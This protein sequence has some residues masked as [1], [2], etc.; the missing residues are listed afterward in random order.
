LAWERLRDTPNAHAQV[1][2]GAD[3]GAFMDECFDFV[4]S[5]AV[6]QHIPSR[7]VVFNYL[8][9]AR[10]VLKTGGILRCQMNGLPPHARQYDT[11]SGVRIAGDEITQFAREQD[12]QLL[13]LEQIWTQYMWITCRK[14]PAGWNASLSERRV[15]RNSVIR[16]VSNALTGEAV[17]PARGPLAALSL[18]VEGLPEE[19]GLNHMTVTAAGRACRLIYIGEPENDAITQVNV[20]LPEGLR[21]GMVP[22]EIACLGQPVAEPVWVRIMPAGPSVPRVTAITDGINLLSG[23]RIVTGSVKV[24]MHEVPDAAQFHATIE[25][26][27]VLEIESFCADPVSQRY[28]FNFRLPAQVGRGAREVLVSLGWRSC[29][30]PWRRVFWRSPP[31]FCWRP[32]RAAG[33]CNWRRARSNS[34][35]RW[36]WRMARNCAA[37]HPVRCCARRRIFT[38]VP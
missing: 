34:T 5:Y 35:R 25:G 1:N 36:C 20:A 37:P 23:T 31:Y 16:R 22:V 27:D 4:Y 18:W 29:S 13:V 17:A 32:R 14:R 15:P 9:E 2:S 10:R 8:R 38:A 3:L 28:E 21:T 6:F 26:L 33:W 19:A 12:M 30:G 24:I 7:E 11:W